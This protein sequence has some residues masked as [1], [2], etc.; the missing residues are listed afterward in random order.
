MIKK[1]NKIKPKNGEDPKVMCNNIEALKV[2]CCDP[3]KILDNNTTVMH[4]FPVVHK[5]V[6]IGIDSSSS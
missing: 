6:Q 2:K 3:A 1:L 5:A 4:L